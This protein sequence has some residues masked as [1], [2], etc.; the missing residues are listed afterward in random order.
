MDGRNMSDTQADAA[1]GG[2]DAQASQR[3]PTL[4]A[5]VRLVRPTQW[6]KNGLLFLAFVFS[7]NLHWS[8]DDPGAAFAL[9]LQAGSAAV[10]FIGL[11]GAT[12][13]INDIIDADRDRAHPT[14]RARP[15]AAGQITPTVGIAL[16]ALLLV[17]S[18]SAA[19]AMSWL[20]GLIALGYVGLTI[21]YS[22]LLKNGVIIDVMAV[23]ATYLIRVLAGAVAIDV[24]ISP[25]LYVCATL[26][27][28]LIAIGKRHGEA[29]LMQEGAPD[30]RE[31]LDSYSIPLLN[32]MIAIAAPS[33]L[34]A[35]ALYTFTAPN[36][37]QQMMLTIPFVI[38]GVFRY[39]QLLRLG[40]LT[41]EPERLLMHDRPMMIAVLLWMLAVVA[42]LVL[43]PRPL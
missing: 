35:Y 16:A 33:A 37:P 27:A 25:W 1:V 34:M 10:I 8:F 30:H 24:P 2:V 32:Q 9:V 40:K 42:I 17:I 29:T 12:Y 41:G 26:G 14:K 19:F 43:F 13:I 21:A 5:L 28:L 31:T 11:S 23:A 20:M 38:Y 39:L 4:F 22:M 18:L 6:T 3:L 7:L 36:L 15:I